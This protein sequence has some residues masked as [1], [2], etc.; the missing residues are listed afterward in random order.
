MH[1]RTW[2]SR[3]TF[4]ALTS[5]AVAW[6]L[7]LTPLVLGAAGCSCSDGDPMRMD[8]GGGGDDLGGGDSGTM[9][10]GVVDRCDPNPCQANQLCE[11]RGST[12]LCVAD[13][14]TITCDPGFGCRDVSGVPTCVLDCTGFPCPSGQ[15]CSAASG[16]PEC[17][18]GCTSTCGVGQ[19]C[20]TVSN[21]FVCVDN[22]CADLACTTTE[23][24]EPA[25]GGG[26]VCRDNT[27][28]MDVQCA[29]MENCTGGVCV[30]DV[31]VPGERSCSGTQVLECLGNGSGTFVRH[32]CSNACSD[33]TGTA[34]CPCVDDWDC[35]ANTECVVDR[36][37]GTGVAPTCFLSPQPFT[38]VLPTNEI[39]WGGTQ[40]ARNAVGSAYPP[41]AQA[42]VPPIVINLDDDNGDGLVNELD[43]PEIVF[44]TFCDS[45]ST[46][47]G[48][49]YDMHG[50]LRAIHGGGP[51]KG[52]D[53]FASCGTA[54]WREGESTAAFDAACSCT[55]GILD[56]TATLAAGDVDN[57]GVPEIFAVHESNGIVVYDNTGA[58]E[59]TLVTSLNGSNPAI[60][61]ANVDGAGF[62]EV[63]VGRKVFTLEH[64]AMGALQVRDTFTTSVTG[65]TGT[66]GQGAISCVADILGD[67]RLEIVGGSTAYGFPNP[68]SGV[69]RRSEC[70][71]SETDPEE[72]AYCSGTLLRL[73]DARSIDSNA[74]REGFCAIA[75]VMGANQAATPGPSNPLDGLP[76][77]ISISGG[78]LQVFNGQTGAMVIDRDIP[79]TRG[80]PPNVDDFDGDGFPEI[81]TAGATE[82]LMLDLQP[83]T[84][85]CPAW[86]NVMVDGMPL[87]AGNPTRAPNTLPCS[88]DSDCGLPGEAVCNVRAQTCTCLHNGWTRRT[89]DASSEVT[90]STLFDFN[91]D[92][93]AE[94]VYN[95]ECFFRVYD[96]RD[97]T[98]YFKEPSESRTRTEY[99]VVADADNDGN[100]E[101]L[102]ATTNES[103]FCGIAANRPLLNNGIEMWGD[104]GDFWVSARRVWNQ[105]AYHVTNVY[106]G[107]GVPVVE[108][109]SWEPLNGR[110][111]N[112]YRSNPQSPFG[113]A[114]DLQITGLQV[115]SPDAACGSFS[116]VIDLSA[117]VVN[118]GDLRVGPG[119]E[120]TFFGTWAGVEHPLM[121]GSGP[122]AVALATSLEAG[123]ELF[124][125]ARYDSAGRTPAGL[126]DSVRAVID[127]AN[128][129]RECR[130]GNNDA[131]ATLTTGATQA[132]LRLELTTSTG[133]CPSQMV[134]FT[135]FNDG[136]APVTDPVVR[137]FAGDPSAGGTIIE[138]IT[139]TGTVPAGGQ[140]TSQHTMTVPRSLFQLFGVVDPNN[141]VPECNDGN[142]R[143]NLPMSIDC[144]GFG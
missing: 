83:A 141:V 74:L 106:E 143:A 35:P 80:G 105:H 137:F 23:V 128:V 1:L 134:S 33:A 125:V 10:M 34:A 135:L 124:L 116:S 91:G 42:V 38:S 28:T 111:Y 102:F 78:R 8:G 89:Q 127:E 54:H 60:S 14:S 69:T 16:S 50:V 119:I 65:G 40:S 76:E 104:A 20:A 47:G 62:A 133:V 59:S 108:P 61:L 87:P 43:F 39:T 121:T 136:S 81:G 120:V 82:Y 84:T 71:G 92:G 86:P 66:N 140:L 11:N 2:R 58:I 131:V 55:A 19:R 51:N 9:D 98:V 32:E 5:A 22:S 21:A 46:S 4:P 85:N 26:N 107:G 110:L 24:C 100:A 36:C 29:P 73:W 112:S 27:C 41:S 57:D 138:T 103:D 114:P 130:E 96:G 113:I 53:Y 115:S 6:A 90:G 30:G 99:P 13:C 68:P 64:S 144:S 117:R 75:D 44:T 129:E 126:P 142:N 93:A 52:Q 139:V 88:V 37:A 79:G 48:E 49:R 123:G 122:L 15:T 72:M 17:V 3:S 63:I 101:I 31:C 7:L 12:Y 45:I 77:V 95:D 67:S 94:V 25:V 56:P 18:T 97:G 118:A 109:H 70:S 132:D